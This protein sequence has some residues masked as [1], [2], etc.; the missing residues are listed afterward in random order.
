MQTNAYFGSLKTIQ[1]CTAATMATFCHYSITHAQVIVFYE[2]L[3]E[4]LILENRIWKFMS[5]V[6]WNTLPKNML[7]LIMRMPKKQGWKQSHSCKN[8]FNVQ[9]LKIRF[10]K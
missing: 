10:N 6:L 9:L 7:G 5:Q 2:T 8:L 1:V 4:Y 3:I